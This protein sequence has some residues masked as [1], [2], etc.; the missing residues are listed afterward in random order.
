MVMNK[1][2]KFYVL[3]ELILVV[4]IHFFLK[5]GKNIISIMEEM[6]KENRVKVEIMMQVGL[7]KQSCQVRYF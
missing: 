2:K 6:K 1:T 5:K 3:K 4:E 7:L